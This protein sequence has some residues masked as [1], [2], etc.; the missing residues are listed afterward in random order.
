MP[1]EGQGGIVA[2]K[3]IELDIEEEVCQEGRMPR[4][5]KDPG[6]LPRRGRQAQHDPYSVSFVV[7]RLCAG[8]GTGQTTL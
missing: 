3:E 1:Q 5:R 7:P 2:E 8:Q 4:A 6:L